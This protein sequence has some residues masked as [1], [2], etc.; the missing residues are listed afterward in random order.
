MNLFAVFTPNIPLGWQIFTMAFLRRS[1]PPW[2]YVQ[3]VTSATDYR[4]CRKLPTNELVQ[5]KFESI[6][7]SF[8]LSLLWGASSFFFPA[9]RAALLPS[10]IFD[11]T[12]SDILVFFC[13][14]W[15]SRQFSIAP[16]AKALAKKAVIRT[17]GSLPADSERYTQR[18]SAWLS[19]D[20]LPPSISRN[21]DTLT[22]THLMI[23]GI[24]SST[25]FFTLPCQLK[26]YLLSP[27]HIM[28][29][30]IDI[31]IFW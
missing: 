23:L 29:V 24:P 7:V 30:E 16:V 31:I 11:E 13:F 26:G 8:F 17:S 14:P 25:T 2:H 3:S 15:Q 20:P 27:Q 21:T 12:L 4:L 28:Q 22:L 10:E 1:S 9:F 19:E 18:L 6:P 5:E